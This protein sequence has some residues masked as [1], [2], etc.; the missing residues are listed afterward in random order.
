MIVRHPALTDLI[1]NSID[2]YNRIMIYDNVDH[3]LRQHCIS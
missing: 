2:H 3:D 1:V